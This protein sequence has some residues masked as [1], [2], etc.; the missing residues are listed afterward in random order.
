MLFCPALSL[1][2]STARSPGL[3]S[4]RIRP[5]LP[6]SG[7]T[8]DHRYWIG[9]NLVKGIG[10]VKIRRL[11][12][13][14]GD[15]E[16]AWKASLPALAEAGLDRRSVENLFQVRAGPDLDNALR[17][18]EQQGVQVLTWDDADYPA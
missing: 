9:F 7:G 13:H 15:L 8:V 4:T 12:D 3:F 6:E 2:A 14:F 10:P 18:V 16:S 17:Q 1:G 5:R 11:L